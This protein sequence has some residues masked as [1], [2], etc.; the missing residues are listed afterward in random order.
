MSGFQPIVHNLVFSPRWRILRHLLFWVFIFSDELLSLI[1]VTY[2]MYDPFLSLAEFLMDVFLVYLNLYYLIP[3][4]LFQKKFGAYTFINA[5]LIVLVLVINYYLATEWYEGEDFISVNIQTTLLTLGILSIAIAIKVTKI[6]IEAREKLREVENQHTEA[7]LK[8]LKDQINPHFLFNNLNNLYIL[9]KSKTALLPESIM[10]LS[11]LLRYQ[12]YDTKDKKKII[13]AEEISFIKNYISLE[14]LRRDDFKVEMHISEISGSLQI[15]PL[16]LLPFI[17]NACKHSVNVTGKPSF[18]NL[19]IQ[20]QGKQL[21]F[22]ISNNIGDAPPKESGG[23]GLINIRRRLELLYP[24]KH[25]I[26]IS[27]TNGVYTLHL[28]LDLE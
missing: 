23:L 8:N 17:E 2:P 27:D 25:Q 3:K 4:F 21:D 5:T 9:S 14:K 12:I 13:L 20:S 26:E 1:G 24:D 28:T 18:I 16:L 6:N 19:K 22:R 10:Q 15:A 11:D 7:V